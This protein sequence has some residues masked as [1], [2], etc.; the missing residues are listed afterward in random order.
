MNVTHTVQR[1]RQS[2]PDA[3]SSGVLHAATLFSSFLSQA[4]RGWETV[5]AASTEAA[6]GIV[7]ELRP[8]ELALDELTAVARFQ[9]FPLHGNGQVIVQLRELP[10]GSGV[11]FVLAGPDGEH[12][13]QAD[14]TSVVP[15]MS[16]L[17]ALQNKAGAAVSV[18]EHLLA[19]LRYCG[20]NDVEIKVRGGCEIP[21]LDG[22]VLPFIKTIDQL[23]APRQ[24]FTRVHLQHPVV[25]FTSPDTCMVLLP[26]PERLRPFV[27]NEYAH[28]VTLSIDPGRGRYN[29]MHFVDTGGEDFLRIAAC[30]TFLERPLA[31]LQ[32][33]GKFVHAIP[34][35]NIV[36][37]AA[38][39]R[40]R[41]PQFQLVPEHLAGHK[42]C[43]IWGDLRLC[44]LT[45]RRTIC[46]TSIS[47][48]T[49]HQDHHATFRKLLEALNEHKGAMP[50]EIQQI[51]E[52][53]VLQHNRGRIS[54]VHLESML[55]RLQN[56]L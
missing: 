4:A 22:S 26:L 38:T 36:T 52:S 50:E 31:D 18:P 48:G 43:D 25:N 51:R 2:Y 28:L 12:A 27:R 17:T 33:Q 34:F 10:L 16:R 9:G 29:F 14:H 8:I 56:Y 3:V 1:Q 7:I 42:I 40:E 6:P 45:C 19:A 53:L 37:A 32:A 11:R 41:Y 49:G 55:R 47:I 54:S 39:D 44:E 5:T 15:M 13:I 35:H 23:I 46:F 21:I 30:K 20:V 24:E